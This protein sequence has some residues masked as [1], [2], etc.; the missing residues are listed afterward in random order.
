MK[1]TPQQKLASLIEQRIWWAGY[2]TQQAQVAVIEFAITPS[3]ATL[4]LGR[5]SRAYEK[6]KAIDNQIASLR[7]R[8]QN[9][10]QPRPVG[11]SLDSSKHRRPSRKVKA[12][13]SG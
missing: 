5:A 3:A 4:A 11:K 13:V 12:P 7:A 2:M 8:I 6:L 9:P 1:Y 10:E